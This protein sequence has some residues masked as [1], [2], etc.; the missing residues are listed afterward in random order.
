MP[1]LSEIGLAITVTADAIVPSI[2]ATVGNPEFTL[3][4]LAFRQTRAAA[5]GVGD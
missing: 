5:Y 1:K 2:S 3:F 4:L